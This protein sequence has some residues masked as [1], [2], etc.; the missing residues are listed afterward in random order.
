MILAAGLGKRMRPITVTT[1]K[2]LVEVGG[3]A[4][5]DRALD[6]LQNAGVEKAVVNVHY[7]ADLVSVHVARRKVPAIVVSDERARLLDTGGGIVK[8]LPELGTEPFYLMNSDSFWIEGAR[9]NLAWLADGWRDDSMDAL[10]LVAPTVRTIGYHG[11]GDFR[12]DPAGRLVRRPEREVVPFVYAGA[13]ILHPR[14]FAGAPAGPFSLNVLFNQ[15][16]EAGRLFG[17]RLDGLWFHVG[18]PDSIGEAE[19]TIADS[20]A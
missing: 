1:P 7:L 2:P 8:A 20:A 17:V 14:L 3:R 19:M 13:A 4:L 6:S 16:M 9:P 15:A 12:M 5:I 10:L 18:T 11:R